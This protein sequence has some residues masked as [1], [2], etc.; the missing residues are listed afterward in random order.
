M[1]SLV[2]V[3]HNNNSIKPSTFSTITAA[4]QICEDVEV[5]AKMG[6][7]LPHRHTL[8]PLEVVVPSSLDKR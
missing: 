1:K 8:K 3:E 7:V 5:K 2:I 6:Q 4:S